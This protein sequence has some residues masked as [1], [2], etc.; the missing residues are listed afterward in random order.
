LVMSNPEW[1]KYALVWEKSIH[2]VRT[3]TAPE[4]WR[5]QVSVGLDGLQGLGE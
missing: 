3:A 4:L 1:F 5:M 2:P